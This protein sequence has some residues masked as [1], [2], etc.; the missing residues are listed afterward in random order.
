VVAVSS[1]SRF[2][3]RA[4]TP[5]ALTG[6]L[7]IAALLLSSAPSGA[8][9][10]RAESV[11]ANTI[12]YFFVPSLHSRPFSIAPGPDGNMWFTDTDASMIGRITL[13]GEVTEFDIGSGKRPYGIV[14]GADGNLWFTEQLNNKIGVVDT[15]GNLLHEYYAP[16]VDARP[17]GITAGPD[18]NI[19]FT[20]MGSG[21]DI[22]NAVGRV[23]LDGTVTVFP[24][25]ACACFPIGITTGP[26]GN[27]WAAEE[28][29]AYQGE[30]TGTIDRITPDGKTI[31]RFPVPL[32]TGTESHL[33][34]FLAP[35]PDG[36]VWFTEYNASLHR[37]GRAKPNGAI[38]EFTLPGDV[39]NSVGITTGPDGQIWVTQGDAGTIAVVKTTGAFVKSLPTH[40]LPTGIT[41]G[42]DG[43]MWFAL[44]LDGEIGRVHTARA[45]YAYVLD[46]AP[47]FVPAVRT[48]DLGTT[49]EWVLEA[50][51]LHRVKDITGLGLYDSGSK[52]PVSF[53]LYTFTAAGTYRYHDGPGDESGAIAVQVDAP[54]SGPSGESFDVTWASAAPPAGLVFDVQIKTPGGSWQAWQSGVT[55]LSASY[56]PGVA[57]TYR[58]RARMRQD[59]GTARTLWSPI[60]KVKIV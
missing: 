28:L 46:I 36:N 19:W 21:E 30:S 41:V 16:A 51:G 50:P 44:S 48:I 31:T 33:P 59:V 22:T 39:T 40:H 26:D 25:Y 35:G 20:E 5:V 3:V 49:V 43:N 32:V 58:F 60:S 27:L 7:L 24:L 47:G 15:D 4:R 34:A 45:G 54:S 29:G 38:K 17:S 55:A 42:P 1:R 2:L 13:S 53:Q 18:G 23:T 9:L 12:K 10:P 8:A 57:G 52:P 11:A 56:I 37:I 6:A 14:A